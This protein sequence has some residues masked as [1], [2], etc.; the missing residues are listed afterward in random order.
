MLINAASRQPSATG[1]R[2]LAIHIILGVSLGIGACSKPRNRFFF[3]SNL[4]DADQVE[5]VSYWSSECCRGEVNRSWILMDRTGTGISLSQV[6]SLND[7][8]PSYGRET[9]FEYGKKEHGKAMNPL[10][11]ELSE[12]WEKFIPEHIT[13][14]HRMVMIRVVKLNTERVS[15]YYVKLEST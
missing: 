1:V 5:V 12:L 9:L 2:T 11:N 4:I 6:A 8:M 10:S 7:A 15:A 14:S 13:G 3:A